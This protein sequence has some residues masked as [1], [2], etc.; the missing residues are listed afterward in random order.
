[1][2]KFCILGVCALMSMGAMAQETVLKDA[3]KAVGKQSYEEVVKI[4]TP[5]FSDPATA[6]NPETYFLAGKA[7]MEYWKK[8]DTQSRAQGGDLSETDGLAAAKALLGGYDY[9]MKAI[10]LDQAAAKPKYAKDA[11]KLISENFNGFNTAGVYFFN[12]K[13]YADAY[14]AWDV[15]VTL[16]ESPL[17]SDNKLMAAMVTPEMKVDLYYNQGIAAFQAE[18]FDKALDALNNSIASGNDNKTAYDYALYAAIQCNDPAKIRAAAMKGYEKFGK[19]DSQYIGQIINGY[20]NEKN[21]PEALALIDQ[22]IADSPDVSQYYFIKGIVQEQ[23]EIGQDPMES[24]RKAVEIDPNNDNAWY[25]MAYLLYMKAGQ[26]SENA[27]VNQA[28]FDKVKSE[29]ID[30]L[31]RQVIENARKAYVIRRDKDGD[32]HDIETMLK[33]AYYELGEDYNQKMSDIM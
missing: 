25:Q 13:D 19:E 22:A 28:E 2:K 4:L 14:R 10:E 27:P 33:N 17:F 12:G 32:L 15:F 16:P 30:P 8:M 21:F 9:L 6:N 7:G 24:Y 1:M 18:Q 11:V 31:L 26:I 29:Q 3:K 23:P 5:A 20:I